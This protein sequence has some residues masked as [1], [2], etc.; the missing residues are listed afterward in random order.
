MSEQDN[1]TAAPADA[2]VEQ[3][4]ITETEEQLNAEDGSV[5]DQPE[6]KDAKVDKE[7]SKQQAKDQKE[8]QKL[9]KSFEVKVNGKSKKVDLDLNNEED[10][11]KY[12]EKA[13]GAEEKFQ[14]A[15]VYRKQAEQLV[16]M[17]QKNPL[18]IL[19]NPALGIDVK[20]L[21]EMILNEQLEEASLSPEQKRIKE[22]EAAI[23]ERE[24]K[25]TNERKKRDDDTREKLTKEAYEKT[26]AEMINALDNSAIGASPYTVRRV[27]DMMSALIEDGWED[28]KIEQI[29][30]Y[31]EHLITQEL[32][33]HIGKNRA[34]DRLEKLIGKDVLKEY[35]KSKITAVK[36]TPN[37]STQDTGKKTEEKQQ[38]EKPKI[39]LSDFGSW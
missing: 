31:A 24:E 29:M 34:P 23:K 7:A 32:T 39:K 26:E 14:E 33:G 27:A 18:V 37:A 4:E 20:Q 38:A 30:P 35:R 19:K 21:A 5:Q 12:V 36:K 11:K 10:I 6:A 13:M 22:L 3:E 8:L 1:G 2:P 16:D 25:E 15:S 9:V 17:L 28:V